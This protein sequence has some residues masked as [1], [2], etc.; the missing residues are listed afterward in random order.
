MET[1]TTP[2]RFDVLYDVDYDGNL[3]TVEFLEESYAPGTR[4][5][6]W[7]VRKP[8][9]SS[10]DRTRVPTDYYCRSKKDAYRRFIDEQLSDLQAVTSELR[11][12][13]RA[14]ADCSQRLE[15]AQ[16]VLKALEDQ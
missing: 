11:A 14:V 8:G 3:R 13:E 15:K 5:P 9:G 16:A 7:V 4:T 1:A 6:T 12:M 10:A 2:Q